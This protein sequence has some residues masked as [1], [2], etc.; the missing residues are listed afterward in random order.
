V[1]GE[2]FDIDLYGMPSLRVFSF[3]H[4]DFNVVF[5]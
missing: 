2:R 4:P 1:G 3:V 5:G